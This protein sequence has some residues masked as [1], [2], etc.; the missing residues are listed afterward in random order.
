MFELINISFLFLV[1]GFKVNIFFD[2]FSESLLLVERENFGSI[3]RRLNHSFLNKLLDLL[4]FD[5]DL[6]E[7]LNQVVIRSLSG[8]EIGIKVF[9]NVINFIIQKMH[10]FEFIQGLNDHTNQFLLIVDL[11]SEFSFEIGHQIILV[12]IVLAS[13]YY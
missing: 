2:F 6:S 13:S 12:G 8:F 4:F 7:S 5:V 1:L 11:S 10:L 3:N 9:F